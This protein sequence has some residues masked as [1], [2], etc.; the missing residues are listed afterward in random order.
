MAVIIP[1]HRYWTAHGKISHIS[2]R[3]AIA[4]LLKKMLE[5]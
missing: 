1:T 5:F 4:V 3:K 2:K